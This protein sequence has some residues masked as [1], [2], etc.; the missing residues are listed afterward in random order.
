MTGSLGAA[1]AVST[2]L[3]SREK[4]PASTAERNASS[5]FFRSP[6]KKL[7]QSEKSH[8]VAPTPQRPHARTSRSLVGVQEKATKNDKGEVKACGRIRRHRQRSDDSVRSEALAAHPQ[9]RQRPKEDLFRTLRVLTTFCTASV[10]RSD[11]VVAFCCWS[12]DSSSDC[13][14]VS[15]GLESKV[16]APPPRSWHERCGTHIHRPVRWKENQKF[17]F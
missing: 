17:E 4:R 12:A 3:G 15:T 7:I 5:I 14:R 13:I 10:T 9:A 8:F 1:S 6:P 16:L 11:K 2:L